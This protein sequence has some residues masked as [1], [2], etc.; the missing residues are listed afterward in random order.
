MSKYKVV[1]NFNDGVTKGKPGDMYSGDN[2]KALLDLGVIEPVQKDEVAPP[3]DEAPKIDSEIKDLNDMNMDE[4][5]SELDARGIEYKARTPK[6]ELVELLQ[7]A[8]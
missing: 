7:G 6:A 3:Q 4:L 8:E 2:A 1:L 5:R